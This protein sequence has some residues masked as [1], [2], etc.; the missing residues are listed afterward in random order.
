[1]LIGLPGSYQAN[2]GALLLG[3]VVRLALG[4]K[5]KL[6]SLPESVTGT[7]ITEDTMKAMAL[8]VQIAALTLGFAANRADAMAGAA[9][10]AVLC[11]VVVFIRSPRQQA[12]ARGWK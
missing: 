4:H 1:M 6:L 8:A 12:M 11:V 5:P 3:V 9:I 7:D 2:A 10:F